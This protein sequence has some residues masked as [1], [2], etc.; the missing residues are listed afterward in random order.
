MPTDCRPNSKIYFSPLSTVHTTQEYPT[1]TILV[2]R[3][4]WKTWSRCWNMLFWR[5][6]SWNRIV[7]T[8]AWVGQSRKA[9]PVKSAE[10][11]KRRS[12]CRLWSRRRR[13][14]WKSRRLL[15]WWVLTHYHFQG[16]C[17][18]AHWGTFDYLQSVTPTVQCM[19]MLLP[20]QIKV[21]ICL[22]LNWVF[23]MRIMPG[24]FPDRK[25]RAKNLTPVLQAAPFLFLPH[26]CKCL[27][28][29]NCNHAVLPLP[30]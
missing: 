11:L 15:P 12:N 16:T 19:F 2:L 18:G 23:F 21:N 1:G 20:N 29:R 6:L 10:Q 4:L 25:P 9:K 27:C 13:Q 26:H 8:S 7:H 14:K 3:F 30:M 22:T 17:Q 24:I 5:I 28:I